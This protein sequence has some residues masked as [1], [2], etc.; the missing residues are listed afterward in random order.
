MIFVHPALLFAAINGHSSMVHDLLAA[1]AAV[2]ARDS[3]GCTP[4]HEAAQ[5]GH[6]EAA[7]ALVAAGADVAAADE[8]GWTGV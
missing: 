4:L 6:Q 8:D 5:R 3:S 2:D 7:A 1:G